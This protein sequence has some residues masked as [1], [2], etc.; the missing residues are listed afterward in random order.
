MKPLNN[1]SKFLKGE[2]PKKGFTLI[3]LLLV[4]GIIGILATTLLVAVNPGRQ[5]AKARD[6]QRETD[7]IAILSAV[8]QYSSEHS[9]ELPDT[10]GNPSTNNFPRT[11]T[12]IGTSPGC[13]NLANAG[14]PGETIVPVYMTEIPK[15]PKL[16]TTGN[17]GTDQDTGYKIFVDANG[18]IHASASGELKNPITVSR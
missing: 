12:C 3:E 13:F 5:L 2:I 18:H 16:I 11:P 9:G 6:A 7:L 17:P 14:N 8:L 1:K 4:I 15:D 10:D